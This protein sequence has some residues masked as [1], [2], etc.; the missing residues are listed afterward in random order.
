MPRFRAG[1]RILKPTPNR[2]FNAYLTLG[3]H[4]V[5]GD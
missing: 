4:F 3:S 1:S 5:Q 2:S